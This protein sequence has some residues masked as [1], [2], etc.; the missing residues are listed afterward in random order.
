MRLLLVLDFVEQWFQGIH[1]LRYLE[2]C[3]YESI[4]PQSA[5]S[6]LNNFEKIYYTIGYVY[7]FE[8][9]FLNSLFIYIKSGNKYM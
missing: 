8:H 9:G 5:A 3:I 7:V 6:P 4:H 2:D 1:K